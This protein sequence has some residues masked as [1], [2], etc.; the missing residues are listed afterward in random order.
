MSKRSH[1]LL[2]FTVLF[3]FQCLSVFSLSCQDN[4]KEINNKQTIIDDDDATTDDA[5]GTEQEYDSNW[6]CLAQATDNNCVYF[7]EYEAFWNEN[8]QSYTQTNISLIDATNKILLK[9]SYDIM[10]SPYWTYDVCNSLYVSNGETVSVLLRNRVYR[11]SQDW[12][13]MVQIPYLQHGTDSPCNEYFSLGDNGK[14]IVLSILHAPMGSYLSHY[15]YH[16]NRLTDTMEVWTE[17]HK[18][19]LL[20]EEDSN[21]AI[22]VIYGSFDETTGEF[23]FLYNSNGKAFFGK[24]IESELKATKLSDSRQI[25]AATK[26]DNTYTLLLAANDEVVNRLMIANLANNTIQNEMVI[27]SALPIGPLSHDVIKTDGLAA[28]AVFGDPANK[29]LY[30]DLE[31]RSWEIIDVEVSPYEQCKLLTKENGS[32]FYWIYDSDRCVLKYE[33]LFDPLRISIAE[34][35][36]Y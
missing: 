15:D 23:E 17:M 27:Y 28:V 7:L 12:E 4:S 8:T 3:A 6:G 13:E 14:G 24:F 25:L 30:A 31:S 35:N 32:F 2:I 34:K 10:T 29:L 26:L 22:D 5:E 11:Y 19:G 16:S 1:R 9:N 36:C 18:M 20:G 33:V 21:W